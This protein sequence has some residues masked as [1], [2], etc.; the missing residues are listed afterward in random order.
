MVRIKNDL[1]NE[2][3]SNF[4]V[5]LFRRGVSKL[6]MYFFCLAFSGLVMCVLT[7]IFVITTFE[8]HTILTKFII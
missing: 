7:Y 8:T 3:S 6:G 5:L 2:W 4:F 1:E